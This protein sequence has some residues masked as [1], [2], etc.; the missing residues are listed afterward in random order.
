MGDLKPFDDDAALSLSN[1]IEDFEERAAIM[2]YSCGATRARAEEYAALHMVHKY[3]K[4]W[5]TLRAKDVR[6]HGEH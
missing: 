5:R 6:A 4:D 3:G 1:R 2:Q